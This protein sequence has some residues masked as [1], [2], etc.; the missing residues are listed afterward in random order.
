[1]RKRAPFARVLIGYYGLVQAAHIMA[2][3]RS[4]T[5]LM[6]TGEI[7]FLA[8]PPS[9]GWSVQARHFLVGLGAVDA[10]NAALALVFVYGYF[11]RS[12]WWFWLG[13][14]AL[15]ASVFSALVYAYG[16][17]ASGAW[18]DH[19]AEYLTLAVVF[20]P[21]ALLAAVFGVCG[22]QGGGREKPGERGGNGAYR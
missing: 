3:V 15:T 4:F 19:P 9:G 14:F 11:S 12:R 7:T 20:M 21:V 2:I 16:T 6:Q 10:A 8:Q 18:A 1:M 22:V 5:L 13:T 17:I